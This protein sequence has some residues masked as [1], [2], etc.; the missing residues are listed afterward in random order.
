[1]T[2]GIFN[3]SHVSDGPTAAG[4]F[5]MA[6]APR[7]RDSHEASTTLE[8]RDKART[9]T[10]GASIARAGSTDTLQS[11]TFSSSHSPSRRKTSEAASSRSMSLRQRGPSSDAISGATAWIGEASKIPATI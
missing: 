1:M 10:N 5:G 4:R 7:P 6:F 2:I 11:P 3:G 8:P 9:M